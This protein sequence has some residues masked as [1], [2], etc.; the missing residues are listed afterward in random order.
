MSKF[1]D[2]DSDF[3]QRVDYLTTEHNVEQKLD[4][5]LNI[6]KGINERLQSQERLRTHPPAPSIPLPKPPISPID[7]H[8][9]KRVPPLPPLPKE[10][11][12]PASEMS[13]ASKY[14]I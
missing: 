7:P 11:A 2:D 13:C 5:I 6:L 8:M 14:L 10:S 12:S 4:N 3:Y 9:P 1:I